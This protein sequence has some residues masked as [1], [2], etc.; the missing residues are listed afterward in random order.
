MQDQPSLKAAGFD[1]RP[2]KA[3]DSRWAAAVAHRL[4]VW[5]VRPNAISVA[6]VAFAAGAGVALAA[7]AQAS[8]PAVRVALCLAAVAGIQLRLLCN[9]IDGM[10]AVEGGLGSK[11]GTLFNEFPDR[12]SDAV[13]LLGAGYAAGPY[14]PTLGWGAA[15]LAV[16]TA[17]VRALGGAVGVAQPFCGP[18]AKQHRM[19]VVAAASVLALVEGF[20]ADT[21]WVMPAALSVVCAGSAV[22]IARRLR[23][24]AA[25]MRAR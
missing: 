13:V 23:I 10:V 22:T 25:E 24:I 6:S 12:I 21:H 17:Y 2:V 16:L 11:T 15:L 7:T 3:R 5:G 18:M 8:A 1:R 19:E 4:T 20:A 9:L 14:G